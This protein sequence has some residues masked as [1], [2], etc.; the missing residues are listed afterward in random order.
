MCR[1][2]DKA[3]KKK[4]KLP[5]VRNVWTV[6]EKLGGWAET[7]KHFFDEKVCSALLSTDKGSWLSSFG[8]ILMDLCD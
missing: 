5:P 1:P 4:S 8:Q 6:D 2:V 7:Q 3:L